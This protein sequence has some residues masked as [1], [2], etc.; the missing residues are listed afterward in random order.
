M[1]NQCCQNIIVICCVWQT[2]TTHCVGFIK[3]V[4]TVLG[5]DTSGLWSSVAKRDLQKFQ[6]V[7]NPAA[8]QDLNC[9]FRPGGC[10][11]ACWSLLAEGGGQAAV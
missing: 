11:N 1:L 10:G 9:S 2:I 8:R 6:I 3:A 4:G 7:L 5:F